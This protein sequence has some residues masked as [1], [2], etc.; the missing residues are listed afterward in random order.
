MG[1][2]VSCAG[3]IYD[4]KFAWVTRWNTEGLIV[5]V[6]SYTDSA[7]IHRAITENESGEYRYTDQRDTLV[8][9][10]AGINCK[11]R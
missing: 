10:P 4:N 3:L 9:G 11:G 7:L 5:E 1:L 2:T 8:P 6:R